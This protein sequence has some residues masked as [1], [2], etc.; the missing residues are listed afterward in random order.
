M[1]IVM[2]SK[3]RLWMTREECK[4]NVDTKNGAKPIFLVATVWNVTL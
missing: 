2:K 4:V 1:S 3:Y